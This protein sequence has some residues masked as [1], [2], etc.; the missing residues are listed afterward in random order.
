M[1]SSMLSLAVPKE[2]CT[3]QPRKI[4]VQHNESEKKP[5]CQHGFYRKLKD[6]L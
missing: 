1:I 3:I 4:V 5:L 2:I 6:A